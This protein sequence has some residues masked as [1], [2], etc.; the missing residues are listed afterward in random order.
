MGDSVA[1]QSFSRQDRT[2]FRNKVR[3]CL[4]ALASMLADR[5]ITVAH[6]LD[7]PRPVA[8]DAAFIRSA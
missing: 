6:K 7:T 5:F 4:D 2:L 8:A 3:R 1:V